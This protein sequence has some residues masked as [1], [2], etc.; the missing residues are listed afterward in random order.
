MF[1]NRYRY[2]SPKTGLYLSQD[3]IG[4]EGSNPNLYAYVRDCNSWIDI[5]GLDLIPGESLSDATKL[6][7]MGGSDISNLTL[8]PAETILNPPG[9]SVIR[10]K[11]AEE[12]GNIM[13]QKFPKATNLHTSIDTGNIAEIDAKS[14][15][16]AGFDV[17]HD[18]TKR[19]GVTHAR[20]IHPD[21]EKDLVKVI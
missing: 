14:I 12:A 11:S 9:I 18:P 4:I 7:R 6:F 20:L 1:Y 15:R 17:I 2:Y 8:K 13:K 16:E 10:A 21:S 19:V 5:F 3:P